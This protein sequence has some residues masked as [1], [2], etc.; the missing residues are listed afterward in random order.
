MGGQ[1]P[2]INEASA[3]FTILNEENG[4]RL[5][6]PP[7]RK[8]GGRDRNGPQARPRLF[9]FA[10]ERASTRENQRTEANRRADACLIMG[11]TDQFRCFTLRPRIAPPPPKIEVFPVFVQLLTVKAQD[12]ADGAD[13]PAFVPHLVHQES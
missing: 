7:Q 9:S 10:C 4:A 8:C 6:A 3:A 1:G 11:D 2:L 5:V 13:V 12:G